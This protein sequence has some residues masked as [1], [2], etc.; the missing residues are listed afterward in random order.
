[1]AKDKNFETKQ[2]S[3]KLLTSFVTSMVEPLV[4][5]YLKEELNKVKIYWIKI[6]IEPDN[7]NRL[8]EKVVAP[9][10]PDSYLESS[11]VKNSRKDV[12]ENIEILNDF[13]ANLNPLKDFY[14]FVIFALCSYDNGRLSKGYISDLSEDYFTNGI[15]YKL[16]NT[17]TLTAMY[18]NHYLVFNAFPTD[19]LFIALSAEQYEKND[20]D[21]QIMFL[22]C[23]E[24]CDLVYEFDRKYEFSE[25]NL[26]TI[27]KLMEITKGSELTLLAV[28]DDDNIWSIVGTAEA[29][30]ANSTIKFQGKL[31]WSFMEGEKVK[32]QFYKGRYI[33]NLGDGKEEYETEIEN[34]HSEY[35][36][37]VRKLVGILNK[38]K[39]GTAAIISAEKPLDEEIKRLCNMN[40]GIRIKDYNFLNSKTN[41]NYMYQIG[42]TNIDGAVFIDQHGVC[43]AIGVIVDG[44]TI[45]EGDAGRGSRYNSVKNYVTW[46]HKEKG[47][48]FV[49][50]I[51]SEDGMINIVTPESD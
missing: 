7:I 16:L 36:D 15:F 14:F 18:V 1:M 35:Q 42:M 32:F 3:M 38:Q 23:S 50:I 2:Q 11:A 8:N 22:D 5:D 29:T 20:S 47:E 27:R 21:A 6:K 41:Q 30:K 24:S 9:D 33:L 28:K 37:I 26:R 45:V 31:N 10:L 12:Y 34:V 4:P 13:P 48:Y 44:K 46:I 49:G 25:N 19:T 43:H 51:I 39:H 17:N 40:K